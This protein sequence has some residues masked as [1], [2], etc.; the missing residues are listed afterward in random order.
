MYQYPEKRSET[1]LDYQAHVTIEES[2]VCFIYKARLVNFSGNGLFFETDLLLPPGAKICI[3]IHDPKRR[4]FS[5]DYVRLIV[6]IIWRNSLIKGQ[7][8]Y[9]YGAK[10]IVCESPK[11]LRKNPRKAFSKSAFFAFKDK[12]HEGVIKN[13]SRGG[14]FIATKARLSNRIGLKLIIPGPHRYILLKGNIIHIKQTGFGVKFNDVLKIEKVTA[15]KAT[16]VKTM[17]D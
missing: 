8:E 13:L 6:K 11:D 1:R 15:T 2:S 10:E 14:A 17:Y 7:F 16:A 9:G 5:E 12:Y 3:G 4:L